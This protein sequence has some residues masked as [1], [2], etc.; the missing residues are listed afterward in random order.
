MK[1]ICVPIAILLFGAFATSSTGETLEEALAMAYTSNPQLQA[2]RAELRASFEQL[3]QAKA[4]R[5]PGVQVDASAGANILTQSSPFFSS[6][7][8]F[9]PNSIGISGNQILYNGGNIRG[10]IDIAAVNV[11]ISR[12]NLRNLEQQVLQDTSRAYVDVQQNTEIVRIRT[13]NV[14]VLLQQLSAAGD[15]FTV[16]EIT[17]TG[18]SQAKARA[19]GARS[20]LAVAK[21][22]LAIARAAYER[23][24]GQAPGSLYEVSLPKN[25]PD[26]L[27]TAITW[28]QSHAPALQNARLA[29]LSAVH[30]IRVAK[31][32]LRPRLSLGAQ[33]R[34]ANNSG[35][36][37]AESDSVSTALNFSMPLFTGGLNQSRVREAKQQASRARINVL[38]VTR[39]TN[40]QVSNAW[41]GLAAAQSVIRA[42]EE[43]VAANQLAFEGVVQEAEVG[44][45]TTLDVLDAE[46]ELLDARL[47]LVSAERDAL[48]AAYSL[49]AAVGRLNIVD[50]EIGIA[51]IEGLEKQR[52]LGSSWF[53]THIE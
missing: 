38:Q 14:E 7:E 52:K 42:S 19:A 12:N 23:N 48:V 32:G 26:G 51:P 10:N 28:A 29:E 34:T 11:Q 39:V 40:E 44:L 8:T 24:V 53:S 22:N 45:R 43:Q 6:S 25:L 4:A 13:N 2:G 41:H 33:A 27:V 50:L 18:V 49:L 16:G 37:G 9:Y 30:G 35:F 46:Q 31:S 36:S 15:R 21:S 47:T 17:R 20:Q 3:T 1:L 5:L